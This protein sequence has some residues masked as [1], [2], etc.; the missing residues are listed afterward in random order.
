[1]AAAG[2]GGGDVQVLL[3]VPLFHANAWGVP[4]AAAMCGAKLVLPGAGMDG[5]SVHELLRDERV[6]YTCGVPTVFL[7]LV[8]VLP[9]R[10]RCEGL[11]RVCA[12]VC[13]VCKRSMGSRMCACACA[14]V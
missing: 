9:A 12:C 1:M 5:R 14:C 10:C 8:Q 13:V 11:M 4:Y 6:T 2:D 7:Y 3:I